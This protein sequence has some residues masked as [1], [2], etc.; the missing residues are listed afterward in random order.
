MYVGATSL[1]HHPNMAHVSPH[2][3]IPCRPDDGGVRQ[4]RSAALGEEDDRRPVR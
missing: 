3:C 4:D 2:L 1:A